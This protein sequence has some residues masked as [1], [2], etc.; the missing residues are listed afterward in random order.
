[1][2]TVMEVKIMATAKKAIKIKAADLKKKGHELKE[3]FK[4]LD[5]KVE[6]WKFSVEDSEEGI[7]VELHT[8]A[9]IQRPSDNR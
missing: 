9:L 2:K 7:R 4:D 6:Q 1:M 8:R 3:W 5:A